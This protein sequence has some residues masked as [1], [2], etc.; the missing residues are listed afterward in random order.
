M[1]EKNCTQVNQNG[2]FPDL[3]SGD[4]VKVAVLDRIGDNSRKA[5]YYSFILYSFSKV[6][7]ILNIV[8]CRV[9]YLRIDQ[10]TEQLRKLAAF[11]RLL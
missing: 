4:N 5:K 10:R 6:C 7:A 9:C 8:T 2:E 11:S 3:R 1:H